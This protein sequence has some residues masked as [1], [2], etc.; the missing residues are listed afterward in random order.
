MKTALFKISVF[1]ILTTGLTS[2]AAQDERTMYA[3]S[4]ALTKLSAAVEATVLYRNPS[5]TLTD[6]EL[7]RLATANDPGLLQ[8]FDRF[9]LRVKRESDVMTILVCTADANRALLEDV[10]CTA[11]LDKHHW[12]ESASSQCSF[13]LDT[14]TVCK[15]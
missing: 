4:S 7:L 14:A 12:R 5:S 3:K 2:C 6:G 8:E 1:L 13:T 15:P 11:K 9:N 10:S